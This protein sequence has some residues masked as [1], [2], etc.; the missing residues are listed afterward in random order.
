MFDIKDLW[1][2]IVQDLLKKAMNST[3]EYTSISKRIML[4]LYTMQ[5]HYCFTVTI[6]AL[7]SKGVSGPFKRFPTRVAK[8]MHK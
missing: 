3:N 8:Y 5:D 1:P 4:M 6:P 7:R 2:F